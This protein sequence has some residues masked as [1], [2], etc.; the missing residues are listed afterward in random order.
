MASLIIEYTIL[1]GDNETDLIEKVN[2]LIKQGWCPIGGP[3][4]AQ[5][6]DNNPVI[7]QAMIRS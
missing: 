7:L 1:D 2:R 6:S 4:V 3:S 5:G